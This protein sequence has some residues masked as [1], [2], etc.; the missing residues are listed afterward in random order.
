MEHGAVERQIYRV[1]VFQTDYLKPTQFFP[2]L[3]FYADEVE[4]I[5]SFCLANCLTLFY[6]ISIIRV[7]KIEMH[8]DKL[9]NYFLGKSCNC[10]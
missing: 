2:K 8:S 9:V 3:F 5:S 6:Q 4:P 7:W 10:L 1:H